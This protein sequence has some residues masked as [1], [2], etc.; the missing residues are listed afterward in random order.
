VPS[1]GIPENCPE[2]SPK[3]A[4]NNLFHCFHVYILHGQCKDKLRS[5]PN[6]KLNCE[7][8]PIEFMDQPLKQTIAVPKGINTL[9]HKQDAG[10]NIILMSNQSVVGKH[11]ISK[12]R[13][14]S[15]ILF[16]S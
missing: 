5:P 6:K 2:E 7:K 15:P 4:L 13:N 1:Q 3:M 9:Y 16:K 10:K 14:I 11:K 12:P 8:N